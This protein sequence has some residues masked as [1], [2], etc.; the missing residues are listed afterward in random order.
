MEV[1]TSLSDVTTRLESLHSILQFQVR[2]Y[3]KALGGAYKEIQNL[4]KEKVRLEEE[5][6]TVTMDYSS[7]RKFFE[8]DAGL[9]VGERSLSRP[10]SSPAPEPQSMSPPHARSQ[11]SVHDND[12]SG[13]ER[14]KS[15][16]WQPYTPSMYSSAPRHTAPQ[17]SGAGAEWPDSNNGNSRSAVNDQDTKSQGSFDRSGHSSRSPTARLVNESGRGRSQAVTPSSL[18]GSAA[19]ARSPPMHIAGASTRSSVSGARSSNHFSASDSGSGATAYPDKT[20][21]P[22]SSGSSRG[23]RNKTRSP[24][25]AIRSPSVRPGTGESLGSVNSAAAGRGHTPL[26]GT[27][28]ASATKEE[29][30]NQRRIE[31]EKREKDKQRQEVSRFHDLIT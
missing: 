11:Y 20:M 5:V 1:S 23:L 10:R 25:L 30:L 4:K 28:S 2:H 9:Q 7:K 15:S 22:D 16:G 26:I 12:N 21:R 19:R 8:V 29:L 14:S 27:V 6:G 18:Y 17:P 13:G 31:W 3:R 24:F